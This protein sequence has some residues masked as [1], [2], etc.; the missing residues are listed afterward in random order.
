MDRVRKGQ[1]NEWIE[2]EIEN[3]AMVQSTKEQLNEQA[4]LRANAAR[5]RETL[6]GKKGIFGIGQQVKLLDM[7]VDTRTGVIC[8]LQRSLMELER[9][10]KTNVIPGMTGVVER[11]VGLSKTECRFML[12]N[13]FDNLIST[14]YQV[15]R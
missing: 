6:T 2:R 11:F 12:H 1:L 3:M 5:K 15:E 10:A 9:E 4:T 13:I 8:Q 14:K 7:E